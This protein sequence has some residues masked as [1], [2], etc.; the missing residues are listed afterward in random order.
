MSQGTLTTS[1]RLFLGGSLATVAGAMFPPLGAKAFA[2]KASVTAAEFRASGKNAKIL[3]R[4]LR[5]NVSVLMGS[6]GN[7]IV[8]PGTDGM[9]TVDSGLATS[10]AQIRTALDAFSVDPVRHLLN[11]HWHFDHT[12]G[13]E[14]MHLGGATIVAH[15]NTRKRMLSR[16]SIPAFSFVTGPSPAA[17]LPTVVFSESQKMQLNG[18]SILMKRYSPA[19]T[20]SDV[21]VFFES[22]NV[23]HTGDTWFHG[24]Y[25]FIDYDSGGSIDGMITASSENLER[26]DAQ[27]I[28]LPGHGD[29]GRRTDLAAFH[30]MLVDIRGRVSSLKE[31]GLSHSAAIAA[32]PTE[33]YD[34]MLGGGLVSPALF[35]QLVYQG[36]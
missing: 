4:A 3:T 24:Y 18:Q 1:R 9:V 27:T 21:S 32:K 11:T 33:K 31:K 34:A 25:P 14:W 16:Q 26:T 15:E 12:D 13:N 22:A 7:I 6:G 23:L 29:V 10:Q 20:D 30:E 2:Q 28:V 35:T 17:A 36:V 8:L 5:G 19:H